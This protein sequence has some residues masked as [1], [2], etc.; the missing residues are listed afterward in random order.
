MDSETVL[1]VTSIAGSSHPILQ[2]L[3]AESV[4]R[5]VRFILIGDSPSPADFLLPGCEFYSIQS[6]L[7]S[8]FRLA[9]RTPTRHYSRKNIGYLLAIRHGA[10]VILETDDDTRPDDGFWPPR[11]L[12]VLT[13]LQREQ[14]WNNVYRHFSTESIWPRGFPLDQVRKPAASLPTLL[15]EAECPIQQGLVNGSPDVD[16]VWRLTSGD[17]FEFETGP[18]VGL[19]PR[20]WCPFNSQ[21]TTW[22]E[23]AFP[24]LFLPSFCTFRMTDIWRSFV[25]QRIC[26]ENGWQLCFHSPTAR[27]ERNAHDL[28]DD[29]RQ[30]IPGYLHNSEIASLLEGL[31]L[32]AGRDAIGENL[33]LCYEALVRAGHLPAD[34]LPL[35]EA[36]LEDLES[37]GL[38]C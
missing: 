17:A 30:E 12:R 28:M 6:Q 26:W 7:E 24:L 23:I 33:T 20:V 29:F 21:N 36:W 1:V 32:R 8:G 3:A 9:E 11:S 16:A 4:D 10:R 5:G 19:G 15:E 25:A 37:L 2:E 18:H 14:G 35:L 22:F 31:S 13:R 38:T 34:E 27:Q